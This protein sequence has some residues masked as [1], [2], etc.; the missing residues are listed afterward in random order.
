MI[1]LFHARNTAALVVHWL[2]I[3][4]DIPHELRSLDFVTREHKQ[5]AYLAINPAGVVPTLVIDGVAITE[6]A[7]IAMHLADTYA[8]SRLVPA[9]ATIERAQ[10]YQWMQMC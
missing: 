2:L 3:E 4:L 6:A 9:P 10:F 7:A 8:P 1:T 5:P